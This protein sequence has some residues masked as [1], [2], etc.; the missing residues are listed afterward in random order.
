MPITVTVVS[1]NVSTLLEATGV[2]AKLDMNFT[3]MGKDAKMLVE[4]C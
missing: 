3:R 4:G 2:N 1:K